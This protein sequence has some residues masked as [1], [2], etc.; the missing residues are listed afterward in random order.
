MNFALKIVTIFGLFIFF[1]VHAAAQEKRKTVVEQNLFETKWRF[2]S[3]KQLESLQTIFRADDSNETYLYFRF[4]HSCQQF[5]NGKIV[6]EKWTLSGIN[7][8]LKF[9]KCSNFKVIQL[10]SAGLVLQFSLPNSKG[11]FQHFFTNAENERTPFAK[12]ANELPQVTVEAKKKHWWSFLLF[13]KKTELEL[14][15]QEPVFIN[16]ELIGGGY[17]GGIDPVTKDFIQIKTDG[18]LVK[19]FQSQHLGLVVTK[20]NIPREELERFAE[21]IVQKGFFDF[22]RLYDCESE[23]CQKRKWQKPVPI[24]LRLVVI[25]GEKKRNVTVTI[26][27][28]E[29]N[30]VQ[31]VPHPSDLD[32]VV[33]EIQRMAFH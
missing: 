9:Q 10:D 24:P 6:Q 23:L 30:G 4:D 19:E 2:V 18:R 16:I 15:K 31:Y 25:Y 32:D 21:F 22:Q 7:L 27:G 33:N 13:W 1:S 28:K 5:L 17:Y 14:P 8:E 11:N 3:T 26:W 12:P 20:R 29:K